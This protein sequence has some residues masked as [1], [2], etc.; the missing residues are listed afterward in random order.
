MGDSVRGHGP[1][2]Y[3]H[4][5]G[6]GRTFEFKVEGDALGLGF[7]VQGLGSKGVGLSLKCYLLLYGSAMYM[8]K[9]D[10]AQRGGEVH[11]I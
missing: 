4:L 6:L 10:S 7:R 2:R 8:H 11:G 9:Q 1:D 3:E 5:G